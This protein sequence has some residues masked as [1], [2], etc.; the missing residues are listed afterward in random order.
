MDLQL[1][2]LVAINGDRKEAG[3]SREAS[4][5]KTCVSEEKRLQL[6]QGHSEF[7]DVVIHV[8]DAFAPVVCIMI[9]AGQVPKTSNRGER[10]IN[11]DAGEVFDLQNLQR[12]LRLGQWGQALRGRSSVRMP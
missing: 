3:D 2:Q 11:V 7:G 9:K 12:F 8:E 1:L 10:S 4:V 6:S 5:F